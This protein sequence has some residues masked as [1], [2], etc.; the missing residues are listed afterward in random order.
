MRSYSGLYKL[1]SIIKIDSGS[2]T[3]T[4]QASKSKLS[5]IVRFMWP[6]W[7]PPGSCRHPGGPHAGPMNLA[8]RDKFDVT[9][10]KRFPHCWP[11]MRGI[12]RDV[13]P[14]QKNQLCGA[15]IFPLLLVI[16]FPRKRVACD[17][18]DAKMPMWRPCNVVVYKIA[19]RNHRRPR[20][21]P[22]QYLIHY[23][24]I[25]R[26][27]L[28]ASVERVIVG[29]GNDLCRFGAKPPLEWLILYTMFLA[30]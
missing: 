18:C 12:Y 30:V 22:N 14:S 8:I 17:F 5:P 4:I 25:V 19:S 15:F 26:C 28:Y 2:C 9:T 11:F 21:A 27:C 23:W 10:Q 3:N 1:S 7:G 13:F 24:F 6:T 20:T 16:S 29:S